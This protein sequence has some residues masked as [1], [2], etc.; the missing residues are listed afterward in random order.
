[1]E[2]STEVKTQQITLG[3]DDFFRLTL[4]DRE[5]DLPFKQLGDRKVAF[6][7]I[8][9]RFNL[10]EFCADNLVERFIAKGIEFDTIMNSVSKSN[11]LAHA[12]AVRWAK[13]VNPNLEYTVV[14]RKSAS[15][16]DSGKKI[17]ASYR[18]VTTPFEQT[19]SL[20]S[21]DIAFIN[22]KK[23]LLLDDVFGGGG[24][25]SALNALAEGANATVSARAV[26]AIEQGADIPEDLI[27]M[28]VLKT[29]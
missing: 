18:S 6:L 15:N 29:I 14:A 25:F 2:N 19:L 16:T 27:Y 20:T 11:A 8:S 1:M 23:V 10:V 13:R 21:D 17:S 5:F 28:F 12:I 3:G 7:D 9:G 4:A 24:T 26:I 22:G